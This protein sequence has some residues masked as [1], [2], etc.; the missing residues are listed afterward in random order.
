MYFIP[1]SV[2][3]IT[4]ILNVVWLFTLYY[5][6]QRALQW[7][8][9]K[10]YLRMHQQGDIIRNG[11]LQN[12]F[13]IRRHLELP[14]SSNVEMQ[15]K[16]DNQY[17]ENI[18]KFH[19]SLKQLSDYLYPAHIDYS[20][21]LAIRYLLDTWKNNSPSLNLKYELPTD[22]R[23]ES[24]ERSHLILIAIEELLHIFVSDISSYSSVFVSLKS[25]QHLGELMIQITY[26]EVPDIT[27]K[28]PSS[29]LIYLCLA[30][31]FLTSCQC[32]YRQQNQKTM[33]YLRW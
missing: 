10:Q 6:T 32:F 21:P 16:L 4:L 24:H 20:L 26:P 8:H 5:R 18:E 23:D 11:L 27:S 9:G 12:T 3:I 33:W 31:K 14:L 29:D 19:H 7:W 30:V 1:I 13:V 17:L 15:Q 28:P 25:H 22:W 2:V